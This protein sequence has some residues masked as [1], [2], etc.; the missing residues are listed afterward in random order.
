VARIRSARSCHRRVAGLFE[1]GRQHDARAVPQLPAPR[2][3]RFTAS[4]GASV[5][6]PD[7]DAAQIDL[8]RR[9]RRR[10]WR[11]GAG[12]W[13]PPWP[14]CGAPFQRVRLRVYEQDLA[15]RMRATRENDVYLPALLLPANVEIATDMEASLDEADIVLGV[16]PSRYARRVYQSAL[17][18]FQTVDDLRQ[19]HQGDRERHLMRCRSVDGRGETTKTNPNYETNQGGRPVWATFAREVAQGSLPPGHCLD[20]S[21]RRQPGPGG[22]LGTTFRC[23]RIRIRLAWSWGRAQERDCDRARCMPRFGLGNIP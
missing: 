4:P 20:R 9:Q 19:R 7:A 15:E 11:S 18:Y 22:F 21:R 1:T 23:I 8:W 3:A 14:S 12:S 17:P 2:I 6:I 10:T 13:E 5:L 16:T